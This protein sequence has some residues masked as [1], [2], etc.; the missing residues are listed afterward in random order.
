MN[1]EFHYY[2][3]HFLA[4]RAGFSQDEADI[5]AYSSQYV[6]DAIYSYE[7]VG[8]DGQF[9]LPYRTIITQNYIFW[10]EDTRDL[11]YLPFHFVPGDPLRCSVERKEDISDPYIVTPDSQ[12]SK[13]LLVAA[14]R[15]R[16]LYRI[17]IALH[18]YADTWAH[19][20][21]SGLIE[22]ANIVDEASMLPPAGHLQALNEPDLVMRRWT[23][24]RL[25]NSEVDNRERYLRA[26]AKIYRYLRIYRGL[27]FED[28]QQVLGELGEIWNRDGRDTKSRINDFVI[29]SQMEF[30]DRSLWPSE[31]GIVDRSAD[32][33]FGGYDKILWLKTA[34]A[35]KAGAVRGVRRVE[36]TGDF[37]ASRLYA[38]DRAARGHLDLAESL[39]VRNGLIGGKDEDP[40][41]A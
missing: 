31:A 6:D 3:V 5:I 22:D 16:S 39:L 11:V 21:F 10:D 41:H 32:E 30:Y 29:A 15:S 35:G 13:E 7:I 28:E 34:I 19:Q 20:H 40:Q 26:A 9:F 37:S 17:G 18:S 14:L 33:H 1:S 24:P 27:G 36:C 25:Y 8:G 23:D 38:W 12:L 2:A 4:T